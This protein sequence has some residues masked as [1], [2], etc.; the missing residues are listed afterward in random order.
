MS[1]IILFLPKVLLT[2]VFE[3]IWFSRMRRFDVHRRR[4]F[5]SCFAPCS[6]TLFSL[7]CHDHRGVQP[8][9]SYLLL[10]LNFRSR[11]AIS[12][13][14]PD[15][16]LSELPRIGYKSYRSPNTVLHQI[17]TFVNL[18]R[19]MWRPGYSSDCRMVLQW[20]AQLVDWKG[21]DI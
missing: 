11:R 10:L 16:F 4:G 7:V 13:K 5:V 19:R 1:P 18:F 15:Q 9:Y 20:F 14:R 2:R 8:W 12:D 3:W 21:N 17:L 6:A